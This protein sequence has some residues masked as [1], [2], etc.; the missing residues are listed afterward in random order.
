MTNRY[1]GLMKM[2][3]MNTDKT[4]Q[5]SAFISAIRANPR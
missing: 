5:E 1:R 3:P 2:T 4:F